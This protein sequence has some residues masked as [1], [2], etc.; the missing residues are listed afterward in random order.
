MEVYLARFLAWYFRRKEFRIV[1]GKRMKLFYRSLVFLICLFTSAWSPSY[2]AIPT[3]LVP[4]AQ[5]IT[6]VSN[7]GLVQKRIQETSPSLQRPAH[8]SQ[9]GQPSEKPGIGESKIHFKLSKVTIKGN[10]KFS[11]EE[12]EAIFKPSYNKTISLADLQGLVEK[13]TSKYRTAGFVLSRA[14]LPPQTIKNGVVQVQVIEGFISDIIVKS[15]FPWVTKIVKQYSANILESHPLQIRMLERDLLL[16]NDLPGVTV[17]AVITPSKN[18]P[19]GAD[20]TLVTEKQNINA[21]A[22]YDNYGTPYLG[23]LEIGGGAS[24]NGATAPGSSDSVQYLTVSKNSE[25]QYIAFNHMNPIG[26]QGVKLDVN[27]NYTYTYSGFVLKPLQVIG[28]NKYLFA[29]LSYPWIRSRSENFIVHATANYQGVSST[30]LG[31]PFYA[32]L[33]R[34]LVIGGDYSN[35]DRWHGINDVRLDIEKGFD[36]FGATQHVN[37]SRPKGVPNFLKA[38]LNLSRLQGLPWFP[39]WSLY[40]ALN[41]QY[42]FEPLLATEQYAYGGPLWG[43][44][45]MPSEI[46]GDDGLAMKFEVR[47]DAAYEFRWLN[48]IQYYAFYDAGIIWNRDVINLL[49]KQSATSTG[50]G[51]RFT[52]MPKLTGNL[53]Y[54]KPLT[55]SQSTQVIAG[56]DPRK[57]AF[58]FQ[59]VAAI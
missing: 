59:L 55:H 28:R 12:L 46:V 50:L 41:G 1:G 20:L 30:I 47:R 35:I 56:K 11:T 29:D 57:P 32:D 53:Y 45:Y 49:A 2:A 25:L 14:I 37:Q 40:G 42:A 44:G 58:F 39:K 21:Y 43:R 19:G 36:I 6:S 34:T 15:D 33:L 23:P 13:V 22:S 48:A 27:Y 4:V 31:Q 8:I 54:A 17:K 16:M 9:I 5:E 24:V 10:T 3:S 26:S 18:V 7:P 38:S 52:F 51:A